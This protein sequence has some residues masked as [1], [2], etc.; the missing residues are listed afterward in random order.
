MPSLNV[1]LFEPRIPHNTGNIA[2]TCAAVGARLHLIKPLGFHLDDRSLKRAGM[3]YW[4]AVDVRVHDSGEAFFSSHP[5]EEMAFLTK[6]A[7]KSYD[8]IDFSGNIYLVFGKE[9]YGLPAWLLE[10]HRERCY[11]IPMKEGARSLNLSNAAAVVVYEA[12]RQRGFPGLK[13]TG[14]WEP[15]G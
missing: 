12:F 10:G 13:E 7:D 2:R 8:R 6:R 11:R 4:D 14:G 15:A 5:A 1:V 9:T 3:D